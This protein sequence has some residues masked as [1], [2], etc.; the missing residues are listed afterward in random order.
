MN[1][2]MYAGFLLSLC[3]GISSAHAAVNLASAPLQTGGQVAPNV[4]FIIDDSGSMAAEFMPDDIGDYYSAEGERTCLREWWGWC[5]EWSVKYS[6]TDVDYPFYYAVEENAV[7]Y[8]PDT[9]Y[10]VPK[11][12]DG[13]TSWGSSTFASAWTDGFDKD[14]RID[15]SKR[16]DHSGINYQGAFYYK[17]DADLTACAAL[18]KGT[19]KQKSDKCYTYVDHTSM[20]AADKQNFA[21]WYSYYR[22]RILVSKSAISGAFHA[23]DGRMRI[24]YGSINKTDDYQGV[25]PFNGAHRTAFFDWLFDVNIN[26]RSLTPLRK[27]LDAAGQYY[28][29]D[30]PWRTEPGVEFSDMLSCRQSFTILMTDGYW[31]SDGAATS[32]A[33]KNNDGTDGPI[34]TNSEG[35]VGQYEA[36]D[37]FKDARAGTLAD[38]AM[39]YWKNDLHRIDNFVPTIKDVSPAFWQHMRVY[40]ISLGVEGFVPEKDAWAAITKPEDLKWGDPTNRDGHSIDDLLHASINS[41]GG[42]FNAKK[43]NDFRDKLAATLKGISRGVASSSNLAGTTTSTQANNYVYQGSYNGDDWSGALKGYDI[44][45]ADTALWTSN[46]PTWSSRNILFNGASGVKALAWANLAE[47]EKTALKSEMIV[48]YLRGE[49][50]NEAPN[51]GNLR[52]RSSI[53][54]D[55]SNSS[56]A[57][58]AEPVDRN[59]GRHSWTGASTYNAFVADN[60]SRAARIYVGANDGFL[61]AFDAS[62]G[63]ETFAYMP[64]QMLNASTDLASY[65]NPFYEHKYFVDGSPIVADVYLDGA[66]KSI[67]VGSL[68]RGGNSLFALDVTNPDSEFTAANV[69]WDKAFDKLGTITSKPVVTRLNN[70]SWAIVV[71]YGYNNSGNN[72]GLLVIDIKTGNVLASIDAPDTTDA[73]AHGLG[74]VEGWDA[75]R[76]GITDWF[77][78]GDLKGNVWKFDLSGKFTS[79][80]KVAYS[81]FPLYKAKNAANQAQAITGGLSLSSEA[82]TGQL[83]VFFGTGKMLEAADLNNTNVQTWYGIQDVAGIVDRSHLKQRFMQN[84]TYQNGSETRPARSITEATENDMAGSKGWYIDLIDTKERIVSRPLMVGNSL[85]VST[86]IPSGDDCRPAG[87]G[88]VLSIDPFKGSRL[89]YYFFDLSK[90]AEFDGKDGLGSDEAKIPA[91]GVKFQGTPSEAVFFEDQYAI[92][93]ASAKIAVGNYNGG[94]RR[95]RVSWR[96][97][98]N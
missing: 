93:L 35:D 44:K 72:S 20:T 40:G 50:A 7:Y 86:A 83:W 18:P 56:P 70:G 77:F 48:N 75:D 42:Y 30:E 69:L 34:H 12:A 76:D 17:Y 94:I 91:S 73:N 31:N 8:D 15:L 85:V 66:W 62:N 29:T 10:D 90:D 55:I 65:S 14:N 98:T 41:R 51:A 33:T 52:K 54:G 88:Y 74:Q 80:W 92:G 21:N 68:G 97:L 45:A 47:A 4:M 3:F 63:K 78:A 49:T 84:V 26:P 39:Y 23:Q 95:G 13:L 61:H 11:K 32:D 24:G 87:D 89:K 28:K 27:A 96:E 36:A 38:V 43:A 79:E 25:R 1:M 6:G 58:V 19:N 37:P 9:T 5:Q 57:F 53:L 60:K 64:K 67:M 82:A 71:G 46:F 81:G 16:F 59:Y 22:N 2:K